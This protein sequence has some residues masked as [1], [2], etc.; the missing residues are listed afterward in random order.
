MK[1]QSNLQGHSD[2]C[3]FNSRIN[4]SDK[5]FQKILGFYLFECP[6]EAVSVR[7]KSFRDY[8]WDK[9]YKYSQLQSRLA[10]LNEE[11]QIPFYRVSVESLYQTLLDQN[12]LDKIDMNKE[13]VIY[14]NVE[15]SLA[16][17]FKSIRN[18]FAHGSFQKKTYKNEQ[19][20][21]FEN[22]KPQ[23][24]KHDEN[25]IRARIIL[26]EKTLLSWIE[27]VKSGYSSK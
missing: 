9:P 8:G 7:A 1:K 14:T 13:I 17:L 4:F 15:L 26:K 23:N 3:V 16:T 27:I 19:Y 12:Q 24:I 18:S 11:S 25:E 5:A 2:W 6:A 21:V 10:K 22:R 20:Y